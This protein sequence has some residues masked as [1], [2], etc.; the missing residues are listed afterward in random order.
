MINSNK[1]TQAEKNNNNLKINLFAVAY[2]T[3][4]LLLELNLM[5]VIW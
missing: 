4:G 2:I 5:C 1:C 3:D